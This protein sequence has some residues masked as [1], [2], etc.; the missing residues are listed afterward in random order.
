MNSSASMNVLRNYLAGHADFCDQHTHCSDDEKETWLLHRDILHALIMPIVALFNRASSL[1]AAALCTT[2]SEDLELAFSGEARGA[3]LC[4]QCFITEETDWC[5]T[6]GCPACVVTATLSTDS[7]IRITA[8]ASLLSTANVAS[9][10]SEDVPQSQAHNDRVLPPLPHILPALQQAV[11]AD[12]FWEGA[13]IWSYIF[14]RATQLSAGIQA[15]ISECIDLESLVSSPAASPQHQQKRGMT[16]THPTTSSFSLAG[17][18]TNKGAK[19]RKS[20]LAK[21]QLRLKDEEI[22]L[23]R[24]VA[25]QCWAKARVPKQIR[26]E[27]LGIPREGRTRSLTCP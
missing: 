16:T 6:R 4:L 17:A 15:L 11:T 9:P 21:R 8:A 19:L 18:E 12:P 7:H 3:F 26:G 20:K 22:E 14:S 10:S 23:M 1:A 2:K 5:R 27:V 13:D 24:R 25:L